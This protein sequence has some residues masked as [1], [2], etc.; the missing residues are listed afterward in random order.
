MSSETQP[1]EALKE[2]LKTIPENPGVYQ[3]FDSEGK[4]LYVGKAKNLKKSVFSYFK[5]EHDRAKTAMLVRR[6]ADIKFII[7][8]TEL[9][10]LL[11][12]N[13][14][15][16]KYQPRYN[17]SLKDDKT[18]PW[19][20]IKNEHFPRIFHT[21][22][23]IKD[24]SK[25]FG[26]YANVKMM[27]NLLELIHKLYPTRNCNLNLSEVNIR[28]GKYKVCLE[29][30]IGNC[31]GPCQA[32]QTEEDYD[33]SVAAIEDI[34]RGNFSSA[35]RHMKQEMEA[36][37][38]KMHFE[39]AQI[40]KVK[41][42]SL[43]NYQSKSTV[44]SPTISNVEV[45]SIAMEDDVAFV[46]F[47]KVMNGAIVLG[48]TIELKRR[49]DETR[50]DLLLMAITEFRQRFQSDAGEIIVQTIPEIEL[51]GVEYVVPQRGDK[52]KL[53]ELS[54]RNVEYYRKERERQQ[55]LVDPERHTKRIL[56]T[57]MKDLRLQ[58][59]PRHIECFD[60]SNIQGAY[61]V[62]A[63]TVFKDTR[64]SKKDYRHFNIKTVE[65]PDDFA[66]MEE[67]IYRRYKR[68][69]DENQEMPQLIVVD[70]G[71]GQLSAALNS[72]EKLNL[73]GKIGIIGIAKRL[74]EIYY[75]GDSVP[76][77]LDKKSETLRIIQQIR[78]EAHRF[79]I[80]HHRKRREKGTIKTELT[81][82]KGISTVTAQAL[83]SKFKSVKMIREC[84]ED[85]LAEA[86]GK[87]KGKI[88]YDYFHLPAPDLA[89]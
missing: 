87:A 76:M 7:V 89:D 5:K 64:P 29:Y 65:G 15:I 6:I 27:H 41:I 13:N 84:S 21:R 86:I 14:L 77:Y 63:M 3:Y 31:K 33:R 81:A 48:H 49:L 35:L 75:P 82:I 50:E 55:A 36:C 43:E 26:P 38:E 46:N 54:E 61:P 70:G 34:I 51:P 12:E 62:A 66:S 74:E 85:I 45:Y 8:D 71:K 80:T 25:Y 79:G 19:I 67:V 44:V 32:F 57:M 52:K 42:A 1:G 83:L 37:A 4:I 23:L 69:L 9:D 40:I 78:D 47:F 30:H 68:M 20:C 72:L 2:L 39:K 10:A 11:L 17:V 16:K 53:L 59:E 73:R 28:K 24:G 58:E 22:K 88:V 60:N 18:F 56:Q